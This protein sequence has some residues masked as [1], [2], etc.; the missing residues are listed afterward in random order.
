[1]I[2]NLN[3]FQITFWICAISGSLFFLI[4]TIISFTSGLDNST[5]ISSHEIS[6]DGIDGSDASFHLISL[7]SLTGF[8]MM[9]GWTGLAALEQ[10]QLNA[11][12]SFL[13]AGL[14]GFIT[15]YIT[16][17][18]FKSARKLIS[19]GSVF[20]I[21]NSV[22]KKGTVY[23]KIPKGGKGQIQVILADM[24]RE[25]DAVSEDSEEIESNKSVEVVKVLDNTTVVVK[26]CKGEN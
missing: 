13:I 11:G 19:S 7:T 15:M 3:G 12:I 5:D 6:H 23:A 18:L 9:F 10:A 14:A 2:E 21:E 25:I 22:G 8:V 24:T 1:M 4:N 16:A 17:L 26:I 20:E